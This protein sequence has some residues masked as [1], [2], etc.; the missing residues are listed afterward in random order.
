MMVEANINRAPSKNIKESSKV[1]GYFAYG[2]GYVHCDGDACVIAGS[3]DRMKFYLKKIASKDYVDIIKKTRF[4]EIM[5]GLRH[6]VAYAFDEE[7]YDRFLRY[8]HLNGMND[9]PGIDFFSEV[10]QSE[11]QKTGMHFIRIQISGF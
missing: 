10:S 5:N 4:G 8:A 1:I 6:G 2:D 9:L 11:I 3:E 7:A